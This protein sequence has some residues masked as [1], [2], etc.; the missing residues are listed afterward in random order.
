MM[1]PTAIRATKAE[2]IVTGRGQFTGE[3]IRIDLHRLWMQQFSDNL[4]RVGHSAAASGGAIIS[5]RSRPGPSLFWGSAEMLPTNIV[6]HNEGGSTFQRSSGSAHWGAMS[7]PVI[8]MVAVGAAIGEYKALFGE[9]P[10][11][12]LRRPF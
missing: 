1:T 7:L 12:T 9:A 4:A 10:S 11:P 2:V 3:I 6:R 5:F 8:D